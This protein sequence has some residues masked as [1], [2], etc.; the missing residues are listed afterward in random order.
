MKVSSEAQA[1]VKEMLQADPKSRPS[2]LEILAHPWLRDDDVRDKI[3]RVFAK[4]GTKSP[5][6]LCSPSVED[7]PLA[8]RRKTEPSPLLVPS[9][10]CITSY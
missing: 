3:G 4:S 7:E 1:L 2:V 6:R 8:K 10:S 9:P 5:F